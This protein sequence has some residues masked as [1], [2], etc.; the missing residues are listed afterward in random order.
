[1]AIGLYED[2]AARFINGDLPSWF[3]VAWTS[4]RLVA[5]RKTPKPGCELHPPVPRPIT[6]GE[7]ALTAITTAVH[8]DFLPAFGAH[9]APEQLAVGVK[10]G[11]GI[12]VHGMRLRMQRNPQHVFLKLDCTAAFPTVW[13]STVLERLQEVPGLDGYAAFAHARLSVG[14]RVHAGHGMQRLFAGN[15]EGA[16]RLADADEGIGQGQADSPALFCIA[17]HPE[18]KAF[19]AALHGDEGEAAFSMDDGFAC[20]PAATVFP[21]AVKFVRDL[22]AATGCVINGIVCYAGVQPPELPTPRRGRAGAR[23]SGHAS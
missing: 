14:R 19:S 5:L 3:V 1:M 16:G 12:L 8:R 10:G 9:L 15:G 6:I 11:A 18:V 21:A 13:R 4:A 22:A 7:C 23:H 2:F 20:A 17:I